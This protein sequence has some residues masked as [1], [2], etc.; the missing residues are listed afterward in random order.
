MI[1]RTIQFVTFLVAAYFF[2]A[3]IH[4]LWVAPWWKDLTGPTFVEVFK[5]NSYYTN[6]RTPIITAT[7]QF[8]LVVLLILKSRE[9]TTLSFVLKTISFVALLV[10]TVIN[11]QVYQNYSNQVLS[12][13]VASLPANWELVK[14]QVFSY[15]L[16]SG[17]CMTGVC[18]LL[19][20][21]FFFSGD[22]AYTPRRRRSR[23]AE[24]AMEED[25]EHYPAS[26][27]ASV[28]L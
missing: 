25:E 24:N 27:E 15:Q 23:S 17:I 4:Q 28:S 3:Y 11:N 18:L 2:G 5:A 21:S 9:R 8:L 6:V 19:F 10:C 12:W 7:L 22:F 26:V 1:Q 13:N 20:A 14:Q 16:I